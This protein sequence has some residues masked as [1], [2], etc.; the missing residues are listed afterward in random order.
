MSTLQ[1]PQA[2][3][4]EIEKLLAEGLTAAQIE[5]KTGM[6]HGTVGK[7]VRAIRQGLST[8]PKRTVD[9]AQSSKLSQ[10]EERTDSTWTIS[11]PETRICTLEQ[12]LEHCK[13]DIRI[14]DVERFTCN[15]WEMGIKKGVGED[16]RIETA[17][18]FQVKAVLKKKVNCVGAL[19]E[20]EAIRKIAEK[21][22]PTF[23][24][25]KRKVPNTSGVLAELSMYDHHFGGLIWGQETG[26]A[27]W[28][29][30]I[31]TEVWKECAETLIDRLRGYK[32]EAAAIVLGNDQQNSDNR[33]G[34]TEKLTPQSMDS[35]YE[36]VWETSFEASRY[37]VDRA[38]AEY[39]QVRVIVVR[40]NHD[41]LAAW[42]LGRALEILY[43]KS[44]NVVID[45][46]APM[47]KWL[48]WGKV[49]L[50]FE[51]GHGGKLPEYDREM[52]TL[53]PEMWGRTLWREAHTGHKHIRQLI[54][55]KGATI[56]SI[57]S[58]RP[59]CAWSVENHHNG[60]IRAAEAYAWSKSEGLVGQ[61]TY[62]RF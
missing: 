15:K 54:E 14:W 42:H 53:Q 3:I 19:A 24:S 56:R 55:Q 45:N 57:P 52:A 36:K 20:V 26:G 5:R 17:P 59:S 40:G 13:V 58:L 41:P 50:M 51:H 33:I 2:Q 31:A 35:R 47:K 6:S 7:Y 37:L 27:D 8:E 38:I 9:P 22:S 44:P 34:A 46:S 39:N 11:L 60:A 23:H 49:M 10:S 30:K 16:S 61:A 21:Y 43:A 18:L 32:A 29:S 62:S 28:D 4:Q 1:I 25:I 48:E 12:L